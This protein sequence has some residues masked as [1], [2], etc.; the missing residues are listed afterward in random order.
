MNVLAVP[1]NAPHRNSRRSSRQPARPTS[2]SRSSLTSVARTRLRRLWSPPQILPPDLG[3][4]TFWL[5]G[6]GQF[7]TEPLPTPGSSSVRPGQSPND[8]QISINSGVGQSTHGSQ[9][10]IVRYQQ[11]ERRRSSILSESSAPRSPLEVALTTRL[12]VWK[13]SPQQPGVITTATMEGL[14][15]YLLLKCAGE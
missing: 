5:P 7:Y 9:Y 3:E 2:S 4:E 10:S 1:I 11:T 12:G 8:R 13:I 6:S 14:I 15:Q